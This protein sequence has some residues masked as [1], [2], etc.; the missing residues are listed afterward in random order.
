MWVVTEEAMHY[1]CKYIVL[2]NIT[3]IYNNY[4]CT[5]II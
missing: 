2:Y 5:N 4:F 3:N 1:F